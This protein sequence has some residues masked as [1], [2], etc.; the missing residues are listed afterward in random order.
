MEK[1]CEK[2]TQ[3]GIQIMKNNV[4]IVTDGKYCKAE[5]SLKVIEKI[6][7]NRATVLE[8]VQER[9]ITDESDGEND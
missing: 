1:F 3:K 8:E 9:Q 6:G 4:M 7:K 5:G 2:L